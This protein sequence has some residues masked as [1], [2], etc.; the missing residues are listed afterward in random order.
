[1]TLNYYELLSICAFSFNMCPYTL[2]HAAVASSAPVQAA[3]EMRGYNDVI[4]ASLAES[5]VGGSYACDSAVRFAFKALS[6][7]LETAAGRRKLEV[8]FNVCPSGG[9]KGGAKGGVSGQAVG[10]AAV[11]VAAAE[12]Q[13]K[14]LLKPLRGMH[15]G[16]T[17]RSLAEEGEEEEGGPLEIAANRMEFVATLSEVFPIQSND[18]SCTTPGCDIR[19]VC[20]IMT[21]Y[22]VMPL[23]RLATVASLAFGG[24]C[25]DVDHDAGINALNNTD[26]P[27]DSK[28]DFERSWHGLATVHH[29]PTFQLN[30]SRFVLKSPTFQLNL[31]CFVDRFCH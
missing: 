28:G 31:S 14:L 18:P 30:L 11:S 26:L 17:V 29:S 9:A 7:A 21:N 2:M 27:G 5:D 1:M 23:D 3:L 15:S 24:E 19:S 6:A 4:A 22:S 12:K 25:I 20:G 8:D 16:N 10:A 13:P